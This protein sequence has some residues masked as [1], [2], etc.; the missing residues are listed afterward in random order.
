MHSIETP[1]QDHIWPSQQVRDGFE[2]AT[3]PGPMGTS[4]DDAACVSGHAQTAD[5][6]FTIA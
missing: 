5:G 4:S 6:G 2:A 1:F 3:A